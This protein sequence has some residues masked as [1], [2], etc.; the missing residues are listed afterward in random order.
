EETVEVKVLEDPDP[1]VS[2]SEVTHRLI[3]RR[4][5]AIDDDDDED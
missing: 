1:D 5:R 4:R 2:D 3:K